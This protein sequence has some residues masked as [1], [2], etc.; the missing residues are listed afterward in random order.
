MKRQ[1][2]DNSMERNEPHFLTPE[3]A[4]TLQFYKEWVRDAL[5]KG[6]AGVDGLVDYRDRV[7]LSDDDKTMLRFKGIDTEV[8]E[9]ACRE[10]TRS[11][12][13]EMTDAINDLQRN[14]FD[15]GLFHVG[16]A[17]GGEV[18]AIDGVTAVGTTV[19]PIIQGE[20]YTGPFDDVYFD[21]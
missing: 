5:C 16:L 10:L 13:E 7:T 14:V 6:I 20:I 2:Q 18:V 19:Y 9:A 17:I 21:R 3:A 1:R 8:F 15:A 11:I 4:E 12:D